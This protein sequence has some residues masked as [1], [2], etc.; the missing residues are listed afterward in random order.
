MKKNHTQK[1]RIM[2]VHVEFNWFMHTYVSTIMYAKSDAQIGVSLFFSVGFPVTNL[3][4][5][6]CAT[7]NACMLKIYI[8]FVFHLTICVRERAFFV[9]KVIFCY[10]LRCF[11]NFEHPF[12]APC[13]WYHPNPCHPIAS[14]CISSH[15]HL[16]PYTTPKNVIV[17]S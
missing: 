6:N 17:S 15:P 8:F 11:N 13:H 12:V 3:F 10:F 1:N 5:P 9:W 4:H 7:F 16:I 14:H 2:Y